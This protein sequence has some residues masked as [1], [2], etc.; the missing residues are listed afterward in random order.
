[1]FALLLSRAAFA[2]PQD[3]NQDKSKS[4]LTLT[5]INIFKKS[6]FLS[7]ML[8]IKRYFKKSIHYTPF[9]IN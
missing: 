4:L 6:D 9:Y 7:L 3:V 2:Q 1:M 5:K 8:S